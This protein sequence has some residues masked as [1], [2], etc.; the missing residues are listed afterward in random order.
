MEEVFKEDKCV[1]LEREKIEKFLDE[2]IDTEI[3]GFL[4]LRMTRADE[5]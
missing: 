3:L 4:Q 2:N 5:E 1:C